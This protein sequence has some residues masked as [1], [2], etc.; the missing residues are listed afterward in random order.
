[1]ATSRRI[2]TFKNKRHM[3]RWIAFLFARLIHWCRCT[4][5]I[6]TVDP[7]G[8][9]QRLEPWPAVFV[10]WHNRILFLADCFP[11]QLGKRAAVIISAS[12]DGEYAASV[13][14]QFGLQVVRG[15]SSRGGLRA[16]R[17]LKRSAE[18]GLSV[19]LALDGPRG[20]RYEAQPG[21]AGL[22]RLCNLPVIPVS[23]NARRRWE[24]KG[25]DRTQI[26]KPFSK[27]ELCVGA[28]LRPDRV[29][30][31]SDPDGVSACVRDALLR[32]TDDRRHNAVDTE[33]DE[34]VATDA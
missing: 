4:Y 16:L 21:A 9:L 24:L 1:M 28:P 18:A 13:I 19:V 17:E 2:F 26:P 3:P 7:S 14:R 33:T 27:V 23:L 31:P 12:R 29:A 10:F 11:G 34:P 22:A 6:R 20:P 30:D 25:W 32:I 15:S 5:R 8:Y